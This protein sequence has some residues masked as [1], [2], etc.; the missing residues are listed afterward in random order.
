MNKKRSDFFLPYRSDQK[1]QTFRDSLPVGEN[2]NRREQATNCMDLKKPKGQITVEL[3]LLLVAM[4][5][6]SYF[7]LNQFKLP[8]KNPFYN[9]ISNPWKTIG[10]MIESGSWQKRAAAK[11][12]HPNH[13]KR[14]FTTE[15]VD[16]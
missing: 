8:N 15:G 4:V 13:W 16:P 5:G 7:V 1:G 2:K 9:F 10:G 12:K 11:S 6:A 3:V 14:M